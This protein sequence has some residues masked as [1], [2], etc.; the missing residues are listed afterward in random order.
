MATDL[1]PQGSKD[2]T[3][4]LLIVTVGLGAYFAFE[5]NVR[6]RSVAT[7][8]IWLA[9]ICVIPIWANSA[10]RRQVPAL[11]LLCTLPFLPVMLLASYSVSPERRWLLAILVPLVFIATFSVAAVLLIAYGVVV[12]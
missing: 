3:W 5:S 1:E 2:L 12:P 8:I 9:L 10:S 6:R 11:A 4:I 7:A